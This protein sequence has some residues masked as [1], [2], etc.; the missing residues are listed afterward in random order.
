[1]LE[2]SF[3]SFHNP[4][5]Q[6][7]RHPDT[8]HAFVDYRE[9]TALPRETVHAVYA[10]LGM[11]VSDTYDSY[12]QANAEREKSHHSKFEYSLGEYDLSGEL[13]EQ[14]LGPFYARYGW[15]R[16]AAT[17]ADDASSPATAAEV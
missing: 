16:V 12:L 11:T 14:R 17:G 5:E 15:P 7:A 4:A 2:P 10:A 1:L 9:L 6:L 13:L 3:E 8:P